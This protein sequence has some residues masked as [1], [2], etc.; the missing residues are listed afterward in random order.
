[1]IKYAINIVEYT[2]NRMLIYIGFYIEHYRNIHHCQKTFLAQRLVVDFSFV[3]VRNVHICRPPAVHLRLFLLRNGWEFS[4]KLK[5]IPSSI[6]FA[7]SHK[8]KRL[9][10]LIIDREMDLSPNRLFLSRQEKQNLSL[11]P[12]RVILS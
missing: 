7:Y 9:V 4:G 2:F 10:I 5:H 6:R 3:G 11:Q 12:E 1:M 8:I